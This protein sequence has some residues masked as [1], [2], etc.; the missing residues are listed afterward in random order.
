MKRTSLAL[1]TAIAAALSGT[2]HAF[3]DTLIHAGRLIDGTGAEA[4]ER[5]TLVIKDE[6]IASIEN[7]FVEGDDDDTVIDRKNSTVMPGFIDMHTRLTS[8]LGPGSYMVRYT[9]NAADVALTAA[10]FAELTLN[11]GFTTVRDLGDS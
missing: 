7:G 3:A 9:D 2:T 10:H 6:R 11:A 4:R 5:V 8:Q 1:A